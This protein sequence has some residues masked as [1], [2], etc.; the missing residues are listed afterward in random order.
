[1][2]L[3]V[4]R[5]ARAVGSDELGG[6]EDP[7][8]VALRVAVEDG[9]AVAYGD[10]GDRLGAGAVGG[11]GQDGHGVADGVSGE[12]QLGRDQQPG[13]GIGGPAG[14]LVEHLQVLGDGAGPSGA[15][16]QGGAQRRHG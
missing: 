11:L 6:V 10:L 7:L 2:G 15:L 1:M 12:E 14:G 8:P 3:A 5:E 4:V 9:E 13:S 16:E